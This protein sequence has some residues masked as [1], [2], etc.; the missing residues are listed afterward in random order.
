MNRLLGSQH[1]AGDGLRAMRVRRAPPRL[2]ECRRHIEGC[3][4]IQPFTVPAIDVAEARAADANSVFEHRRKNRF[5]LAGRAG[6]NAQHFRRRRLLLQRFRQLLRTLLFGLEQPR[7]LDGDHGLVG[8]A[9]LEGK[10][11]VG[12]GQEP[13]TEDDENADCLALASERCAADGAGTPCPGVGQAG[14]VGH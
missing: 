13:I 7:V 5:K 2:R 14:K 9:L 3:R 6:Y 8:E 12:E 4:D 11:I 10:L 1:A